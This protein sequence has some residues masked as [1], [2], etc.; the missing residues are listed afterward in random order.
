MFLGCECKVIGIVYYANDQWGGD[1]RLMDQQG[2]YACKKA[3]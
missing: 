1:G 2:V 3:S